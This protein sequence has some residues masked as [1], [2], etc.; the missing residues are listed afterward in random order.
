MDDTVKQLPPKGYSGAEAH[1]HTRQALEWKDWHAALV[2]PTIFTLGDF[3]A[4]W[5]ALN[6][7]EDT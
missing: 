2:K 4:S 3:H 1:I 5:S 7:Q 6:H